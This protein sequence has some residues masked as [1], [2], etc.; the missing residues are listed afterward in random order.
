MDTRAVNGPGWYVISLRPRGGHAGLRAAA[1]RAGAGLV[2]LSPIVLRVREDAATRTELANALQAPRVVFTSPG[3]ASAAA[4]LQT[5]QPSP[6]AAWC[7]V[8]AGTAAAL[9]R[10]GVRPVLRP[11]RMDSEGLLGLPALAEVAGLDVA[12]IT[13]P[14][15][16]DALAPALTARGARVHRIDVYERVPVA[17]PASAV[18]ALCRLGAPA[19]IALTSGEALR[20]ALSSLPPDA[21]RCLRAATAVVPSARL[22]DLARAEGFTRIVQALGPR[23]AQIVATAAQALARR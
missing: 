4:R 11:E 23:P 2:A 3:A 7:A 16:R 13:A 14:G 20:Q 19:A 8:G 22:A 1:K 17:P 9:R 10:A 6:G 18:A 21:Q 12:L 5:L 15:G